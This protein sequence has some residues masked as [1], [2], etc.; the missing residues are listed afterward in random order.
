[1]QLYLIRHG[2]SENNHLWANTGSNEGRHED[3]E[4]TAVGRQQAALVAGFLLRGDP[5]WADKAFDPQNV[6]GFGI[7]HVYCSLMVRAVATGA[8]IAGALGLPVMGLRS[9]HETGGIY[10]IDPETGEPVGLPGRTRSYFELHYPT[11]RLPESLDENG[12]WNRP[13]EEDDEILPRAQ[14]VLGMLLTQHGNTDDHV[15]LVTHG[16]FYNYLVSALLGIPAERRCWFGL[17]NAGITR[18]DF[19]PDRIRLVYMNRVDFLPVT[20][21]T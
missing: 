10:Q 9:A 3:P 7:T 13:R 21:I 20:L 5:A 8:V 6:A 17:N 4:L 1:M 11:L 2:Q 15:A 14:R 18:I 16:G 19:A 12:W